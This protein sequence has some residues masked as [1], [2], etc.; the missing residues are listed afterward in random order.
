MVRSFPAGIAEGS[1]GFARTAIAGV[2][3]GIGH[4][5][6]YA[7]LD[8]CSATH[9]SMTS[10]AFR[11]ASGRSISAALARLIEKTMFDDPVAYCFALDRFLHSPVEPMGF[12]RIEMRGYAGRLDQ[13]A[14][15]KSSSLSL[16]QRAVDPQ[17]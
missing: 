6:R 10:R 13:S 16:L 14:Q 2:A 17:T 4:R 12:N 11:S 9:R 3:D 7:G 5:S 1:V 15:R 8:E